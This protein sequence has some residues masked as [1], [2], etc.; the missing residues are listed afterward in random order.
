MRGTY[1]LF[2]L[3]NYYGTAINLNDIAKSILPAPPELPKNNTKTP[4]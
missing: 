3:I 2:I 1:F 4:P